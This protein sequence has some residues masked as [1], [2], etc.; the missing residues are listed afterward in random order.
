MT[1]GTG[2]NISVTMGTYYSGDITGV[3]VDWNHNYSFTDAGEYFALTSSNPAT[4]TITP[5]AGATTGSTRMRIRMQY[6][7]T[8][9]PCGT[10]TYGEVEDYTVNVS[11]ASNMTYVSSTSTQNLLTGIGVPQNNA[12]IL[13]IQIVTSGNANPLNATSFT[14]NTNG[15]T[16]PTSDITFAKLWYTGTSSTF[17][18][19]TQFGSNFTNPN[20][21]FTI[22]GTQQL[23][24][25]TNYFWLTYDCPGTAIAGKL[26]RISS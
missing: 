13:G 5:P 23:Q 8:L 10:Q 16:A 4:G 22:T 17:G 2:Y 7:G 11:A 26:G 18:T 24:T 15:S 21:S 19:T 1:I 3:W 14:L 12:Q 6:N 9:D 25:G 20:G